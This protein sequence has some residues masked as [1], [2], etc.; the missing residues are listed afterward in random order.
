M[1]CILVQMIVPTATIHSQT[2]IILAKK[3]HRVDG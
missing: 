1:D 2:L 3:H